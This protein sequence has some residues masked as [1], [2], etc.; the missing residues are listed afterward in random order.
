MFHFQN[1]VA[2]K[3]FICSEIVETTEAANILGCSRQYIDQLVKEQQ[4]IPIKILNRN[5]LFY[6]PHVLARKK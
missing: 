6:K 3:D 2:L 1:Y 4:L 5:K